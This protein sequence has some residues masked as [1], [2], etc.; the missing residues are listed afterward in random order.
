MSSECLTMDCWII[1][2][3][4][5]SA[6]LWVWTEELVDSSLRLHLELPLI[7]RLSLGRTLEQVRDLL[8]LMF[9]KIV[10]IL[11]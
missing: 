5:D 11:V 7:I 10:I 2:G 3:R 1:V 4:S 8:S 6:H 9:R